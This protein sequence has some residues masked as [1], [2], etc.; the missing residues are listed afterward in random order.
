MDS[1]HE[2]REAS[3]TERLT[4]SLYRLLSDYRLTVTNLVSSLLIGEKRQR[5]EKERKKERMKERE[6]VFSNSKRSFYNAI[7]EGV[8]MIRESLR[9]RRGTWAIEGEGLLGFNDL[10]DS[11]RDEGEHAD[12][13]EESEKEGNDVRLLV[14][15][16]QP[17]NSQVSTDSTQQ[18]HNQ[19]VASPLGRQSMKY[20]VLSAT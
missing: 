14:L 15:L 9:R 17:S 5:D 4:L 6:R 12:E 10:I 16:H 2:L 8:V 11:Q 7:K 19:E 13:D 3:S 20:H 1:K 18:S